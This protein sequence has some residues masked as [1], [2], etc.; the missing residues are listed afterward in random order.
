MCRTRRG[1]LR[2]SS[3]ART[4]ARTCAD[5]NHAAFIVRQ[6]RAHGLLHAQPHEYPLAIGTSG[7]EMIG[8]VEAVDAPGFDLEPGS[9]ALV[10]AGRPDHDGGVLPGEA[11][12]GCPGAARR[13]APGTPADGAA[14]GHGHLRPEAAAQ[15]LGK[16]VVV[17]GQ[18]SAGLFFDAMCRRIGRRAGHRHGP[19]QMRRASAGP[20]NGRDPQR[21]QRR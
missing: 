19:R 4:Q 16:N 11:R 14:A 10:L 12:R 20:E 9:V 1:A 6:R 21:Q 7:H 17:I 15:H 2:G 18:G 5:Q 8:V 3:G 13:A